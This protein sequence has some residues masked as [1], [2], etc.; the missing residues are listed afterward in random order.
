MAEENKNGGT[1]PAEMLLGREL[2]GGWIVRDLVP[3]LTGATGGS[4]SVGYVVERA[5]QKAFLKAFDYKE[6]FEAED[7]APVL[8][9][10]TSAYTFEK[11]LLEKC[12]NDGLSRIVRSFSSGAIR[13]KE[14]NPQYVVQYVIFE[15][16]DADVR[17]FIKISDKANLAWRFRT[18]RQVATGLAQLHQR[19]IAHQDLKPSNVLVFNSEIC[20]IADLGRASMKDRE[21][22]YDAMQIPGAWSYASPE[23]L[24][25]FPSPD[26]EERRIGLDLYHLGSLVFFFFTGLGTTALLLRQL[27]NSHRPENWRGMFHD[28]LPYLIDAYE[29]I[30]EELRGHVPASMQEPVLEIVRHLCFPDPAKRGHPKARAFQAGRF[31]LERYI[32]DFNSLSIRAEIELIRETR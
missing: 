31:Q 28:V 22:P 7:P 13:I 15:L 6:A 14:D 4:F 29:R 1:R 11:D 3:R 30:L 9:L 19:S 12:A 18:L 21:S 5:G 23:S 24:Y 20:K 16:A 27:D 32:S 26:W 25:R 10:L 8:S 2:S 17:S